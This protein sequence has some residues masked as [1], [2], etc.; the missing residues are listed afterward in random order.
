MCERLDVN[1][2]VARLDVTEYLGDWMS[3]NKWEVGCQ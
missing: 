2:S 3:L 1:E